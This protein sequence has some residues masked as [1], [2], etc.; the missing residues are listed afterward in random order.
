MAI[1]DRKFQEAYD[2]CRDNESF[3]AGW[4]GAV[5]LTSPSAALRPRRR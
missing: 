4:S 1:K 2:A 5:S 3:L